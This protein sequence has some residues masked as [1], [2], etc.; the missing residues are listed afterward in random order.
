MQDDFTHRMKLGLLKDG[1]ALVTFNVQVNE[2]VLRW[3][4]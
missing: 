2:V 1:L 4:K 3:C